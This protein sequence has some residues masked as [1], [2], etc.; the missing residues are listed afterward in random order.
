MLIQKNLFFDNFKKIPLSIIVKIIELFIFENKKWSE[1]FKY[2]LDYYQIN[3]LNMNI[4]YEILTQLRKYIAHFL[5]ESYW[6][7]NEMAILS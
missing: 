1:I 2:L 7:K 4:V 5:K 6:E 3:I